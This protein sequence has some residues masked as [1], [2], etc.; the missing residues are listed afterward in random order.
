MS[1][2]I[3]DFILTLFFVAVLFAAAACV[4][5]SYIEAKIPN[6]SPADKYSSVE[7]NISIEEAEAKYI[8]S[9]SADTSEAV[10]GALTERI[11]TEES[12]IEKYCT[13]GMYWRICNPLTICKKYCDKFVG[14]DVTSSMPQKG[15]QYA[16][17][18]MVTKYTDDSFSYVVND[19]D[20][21]NRAES[22]VK[23]AKEQMADG[24]NFLFILHPNKF[25]GTPEYK[26]YSEKKRQELDDILKSNSIDYLN[27][28]N[29]LNASDKNNADIFFKGDHHWL[30]QTALKANALLCN[31]LND[32]YGKSID[33]SVFDL[34]NY[35]VEVLNNI[36]YGGY[37][38]KATT[39]YIAPDDLP[40]LKPKY[41]SNLDVC[42]YQSDCTIRASGT[43]EQTLYDYS[44]I[45]EHVNP[46]VSSA[47]GLYAYNNCPFITIHNNDVHNASK[48]ML[49]KESFAN[50]AIPT[51][52]TAF[53]DMYI[54]DLRLFGG[55]LHEL[56]K[57]KNPDTVI[58][59]YGIGEFVTGG[60]ED[61]DNSAMF[62]FD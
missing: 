21:T 20:I 40:V 23:F 35:D 55:N 10:D 32:H 3:S 30:P 2:K 48:I 26:D 39:A 19:G 42:I 13:N 17:G 61:A 46:Y 53:E 28:H 62:Q 11:K 29:L 27:L 31:Y 8:K 54:V 38:R 50:A 58:I 44:R 25:E 4:A 15:G 60:A 34:A 16:V 5:F 51:L 6:N 37:L 24:R 9:A 59:M 52:S 45:T 57:E 36:F 56:I 14:L 22:V 12:K 49:I 47:Y 18:D 43:I 41:S 7:A 33:T 1:K